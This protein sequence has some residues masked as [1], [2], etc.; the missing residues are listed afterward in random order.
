MLN[1]CCSTRAYS[2]M[3]SASI[4]LDDS[5]IAG[6]GIFTYTFFSSISLTLSVESY[7]VKRAVAKQLLHRFFVFSIS[8]ELTLVQSSQCFFLQN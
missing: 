7:G 8:T 4:H 2:T 6:Q 5:I 3:F 1:I